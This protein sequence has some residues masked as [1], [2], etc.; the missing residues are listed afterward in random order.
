[1]I[2]ESKLRNLG[3]RYSKTELVNVFV[4]FPPL[5]DSGGFFRCSCQRPNIVGR[6]SRGSFGDLWHCA[7]CDIEIETG[8]HKSS[9][10]HR[11]LLNYM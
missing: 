7:R 11:Q 9:A 5:D 8:S 1:M 2:E 4:V 3:V 6:P 10:V